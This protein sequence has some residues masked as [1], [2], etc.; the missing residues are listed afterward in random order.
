MLKADTDVCSM[1]GR[2][3]KPILEENDIAHLLADS[4]D[5]GEKLMTLMQKATAYDDAAKENAGKFGQAALLKFA[6]K[7]TSKK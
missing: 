3:L 4:G 7:E 5:L 2:F 6:K 1:L